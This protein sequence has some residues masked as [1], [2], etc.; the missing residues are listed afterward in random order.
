MATMDNPTPDRKSLLQQR[1]MTISAI[2]DA[3]GVTKGHVSRVVAGQRRSPRLERAIARALRMPLREAFP[4][5]YGE[6]AA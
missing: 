3:H 6:R 2:A 5:W 1:R 4:E